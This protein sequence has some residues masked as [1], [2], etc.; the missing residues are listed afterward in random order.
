M[1]NDKQAND[2]RKAPQR[3]TGEEYGSIRGP[4]RGAS[5]FKGKGNT[6][7]GSEP[8]LRGVSGRRG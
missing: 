7:R 5:D 3:Q 2:Q 8:E 1:R 4:Q 6:P